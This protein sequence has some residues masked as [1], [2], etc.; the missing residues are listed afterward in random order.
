[1]STIKADKWAS[2]AGDRLDSVVQAVQGT[3]N[4]TYRW[5]N[6]G[7]NY[8]ALPLAVT[9]TPKLTNSLFLC[10]VDVQGYTTTYNTG[11]NYGLR[12]T[13][14]GVNTLIT[15][16]ETGSHGGVADTWMGFGHGS[17]I[18]NSSY[19]KAFH[20]LDAPNVSAGTAITYTVM[21]GGWS[22]QG[23]IGLGWSTFGHN[24]SVIVLEISN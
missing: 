13:T 12:R 14:G 17:A 7:T 6:P 24:S 19:S 20:Q 1:M 23:G 4:T 16:F 8:V 5:D 2:L 15:G 21:G 9:I 11:W 3:Y 18:T 10:F 22:G